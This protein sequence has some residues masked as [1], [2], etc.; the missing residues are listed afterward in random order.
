MLQVGD[1]IVYPMH[2]AGVVEAVEEKEILGEP[3]RYFVL[4]ICLNEMRVLLPVEKAEQCGI[5]RIADETQVESV[6]AVLRAEAADSLLG[7]NR[8]Y[9][10]NLD[11]L[12]SGDLCEVATVVRDLVWRDDQKGLSA[13]ERKLLEHA[14]Q[15]L[16]GEL[17]LARDLDEA[18]ATELIAGQLHLG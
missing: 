13:G 1:K 9:R 10:A 17:M 7:W 6:L 4:R 2:G 11:K 3:H 5:R 15:I 12:K 14:R 18:A 8:R 16:T